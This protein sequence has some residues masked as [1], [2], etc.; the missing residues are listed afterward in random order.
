MAGIQRVEQIEGFGAADFADDQPVRPVPESYFHEI[1]DTHRRYRDI[2]VLI[3]LAAARFEADRVR[4]IDAQ[5]HRVLNDRQPFRLRNVI[6][7]RFRESGFPGI[8]SAAHENRLPVPDGRGE[9]VGNG[10]GKSARSDEF[11]QGKPVGPEFPDRQGDAVERAGGKRSRHPGTVGEAGIEQRLR[12]ADVFPERTRNALHGV[13]EVLL[14]DGR[15]TG[16][17][18]PFRWI[19]TDW[20]PFTMIS[21]ILASVTR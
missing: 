13:D 20:S 7:E 18:R 12:F 5:F 14:L 10:G 8:G 11:G 15:A 6:E 3:R 2:S 9:L 1:P 19:K 17:T 16:S 4:V 21:E